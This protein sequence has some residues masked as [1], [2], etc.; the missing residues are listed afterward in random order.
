MFKSAFTCQNK[1]CPTSAASVFLDAIKRLLYHTVTSE[2]EFNFFFFFSPL[3]ASDIIKND[4]TI[5][6]S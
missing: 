3:S 5:F 1:V 4:R 2:Q 6:N